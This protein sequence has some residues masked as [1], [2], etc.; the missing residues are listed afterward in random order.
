MINP[1]NVITLL[2]NLLS[3]RSNIHEGSENNGRDVEV[4]QILFDDVQSILNPRWYVY[5]NNVTSDFDGEDPPDS[6]DS[7]V[8][9]VDEGTGSDD[10][11]VDDIPT[12]QKEYECVYE[13]DEHS[14]HLFS[15]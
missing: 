10:F 15:F 12:D 5:E 4:A 1:Y 6:S 13:K 2:T 7:D 9:N 14:T 3:D 8:E 11:S